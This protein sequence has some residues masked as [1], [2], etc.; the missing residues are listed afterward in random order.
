MP[1]IDLLLVGREGHGKSSVGN[2][3]LQ[4]KIFSPKSI[5]C[6]LQ[7]PD[8]PVKGSTMIEGETVSVVD[9]VC[10]CNN[11]ISSYSVNGEESVEA[12][13]QQA[14]TAIG[15]SSDGFTAILVVLQFGARFTQQEMTALHIIRSL[16]GNDVFKDYGIIVLTYGDQF[17]R[18]AEEESNMTFGDWCKKQP[19]DFKELLRECADRCVLF[20]NRTKNLKQVQKLLQKVAELP[21]DVRY[22]IDTFKEARRH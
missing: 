13:R 21:K 9:A 8:I 15:L 2:S 20:N 12:M 7:A 11:V 17:E 3:I 19:G 5:A 10:V 6:S 1:S 14:E 16:L 18:V 4:A 22:T